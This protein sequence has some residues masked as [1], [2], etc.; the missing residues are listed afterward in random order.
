MKKSF[1]FCLTLA[2]CITSSGYAQDALYLPESKGEL[3]ENGSYY[4]DYDSRSRIPFWVAYELTAPESNGTAKRH[5]VFK[6]DRRVSNCAPTSWSG[7][8]YDR[9]HMKPAAD[10]KS[11]DAEMA[12]S[13]YMTNMAPQTPSLNRGK[14]KSLESSVRAW[15]NDYGHVYV[16]MGP[17]RGTKEYIAGGVRVPSH[18]WKAVLR[19]TSDTAAVGFIFPNAQSVSGTVADYRVSI[20]SL[21][22][23]TGIDLFYQLPDDVEY[24]AESNVDADW[25]IKPGGGGGGSSLQCKGVASSTGAR[26]RNF[27]NYENQFCYLH[28]SQSDSPVET[29]RSQCKGKAVSTGKRCKNQTSDPSGFCHFHRPDE[30]KPTRSAPHATSG[31]SRQCSGRAVSTG[32]RCRLMTKHPSGRCHHHRN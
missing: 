3:V 32:K 4:V 15:S 25:S 5:D 6:L 22:S 31:A 1:V 16:V 30:H 27:T 10:S 9:G 8:G 12:S 29:G 2:L 28:Q 18:F 19:Y 23:F 11:T 14:W 21:E 20:D 26:C 17:S 7:S 24:T 13:F